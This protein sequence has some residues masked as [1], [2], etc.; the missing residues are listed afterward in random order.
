MQQKYAMR[1]L[2]L[3]FWLVFATGWP[4]LSH[5]GD[6][7]DAL[8]A[9]ADGRYRSAVKEFKRLAR[10]GHPDAQY[11]LGMLYLFG[12]GVG[13]DV[14]Q[15]IVWLKRSANNG[16][17]LAANELGQIY[18]SGQGVAQD[19]QEAMKWL[20]MATQLAE[21]DEDATDEDCE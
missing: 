8:A 4:I 9:L 20:E 15:G 18:L 10:E 13:R 7:E 5:A 19:E 14:T 16:S 17:Y 3:L 2:I 12:T 1:F 6:Y 11:Q 21:E